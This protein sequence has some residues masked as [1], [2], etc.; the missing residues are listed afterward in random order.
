MTTQD[1][2]LVIGTGRCG[3]STV[4]RILHDKLGIYMGESF[5]QPDEH[6]PDGYYEDAEFVSFNHRFYRRGL[7]VQ[8]WLAYTLNLIAKRQ[9]MQKPWGIK[10]IRITDV[11]GLYL[12]FFDKPKL[13]YCHR[14]KEDTLASFI[15]CYSY[16]QAQAE[17]IYWF[18][19]KVSERLLQGRDYLSLDFTE[20]LDEEKIENQIREKFRI[21]KEG[22]KE[23][24]RENLSDN[25]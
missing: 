9:S 4:A 16:S 1:P 13:I 8:N 24:E 14:K 11:L 7:D 10:S 17:N 5:L 25:G 15:R 21:K 2:Y 3:T 6:N 19:T 18:R 12:S 22:E 20:R 23:N